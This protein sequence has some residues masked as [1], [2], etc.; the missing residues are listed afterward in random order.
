MKSYNRVFFFKSSFDKYDGCVDKVL[1]KIVS[2]KMS[3]Q[4][5]WIDD[6]IKS[7]L[8]KW[9]VKNAKKYQKNRMFR[10]LIKNVYKIEISMI[11]GLIGD[12]KTI[13]IKKN[14][15]IKFQRTFYD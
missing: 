4:A 6:A 14:G 13:E 15:K 1:N 7:L 9:V 3:K 10:F 12:R 2:N 8:P 11:D 5:K